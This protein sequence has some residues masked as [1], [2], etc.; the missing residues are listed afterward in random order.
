[1][2]GDASQYGICAV[3]SHIMPNGTEQPIAYALRTLSSNEKNYAQVEK[4]A[5]SHIWC[6]KVLPISLW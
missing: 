4:E 2:A 5:L 1:M 6:E 3:I